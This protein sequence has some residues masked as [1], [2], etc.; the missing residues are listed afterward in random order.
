MSIASVAHKV[1]TKDQPWAVY[2]ALE[3]TKLSP[4]INPRTEQYW[5]P[6]RPEVVIKDQPWTEQYL[7]RQLP[8]RSPKINPRTKPYPRQPS[9]FVIVTICHYLCLHHQRSTSEQSCIYRVSSLQGCHHRS[10][11]K[12]KIHRASSFHA[13]VI[14]D[15]NVRT[16]KCSL[17]QPAKLS[18]KISCRTKKDTWSQQPTRLLPQM[19]PQN[20][21][22]F[23]MLAV[24]EAPSLKDKV[25]SSLQI[26]TGSSQCLAGNVLVC[27]PHVS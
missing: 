3:P 9:S 1:V 18:P 25:Q 8:V 24:Y 2:I 23:I 10:T 7:S 27:D 13:S 4:E 15:H 21:E 17:C 26:S 14:K 11:A 19:N 5:S 6:Q 12:E 20:R 22:N 16:E